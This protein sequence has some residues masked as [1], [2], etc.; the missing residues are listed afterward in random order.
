MAICHILL[1]F[2]SPANGLKLVFEG[3][4]LRQVEKDEHPNECELHFPL[5]GCV[6]ICT[7]VLWRYSEVIFSKPH[8][9]ACNFLLLESN[10]RTHDVTKYFFFFPVGTS[11]P[12]STGGERCFH[13]GCWVGF[14][15]AWDPRAHIHGERATLWTLLWSHF[16]AYL[17]VSHN[18]ASFKV[19]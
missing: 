11:L 3:Y 7:N 1:V 17:R 15:P 12:E 2:P 6:C 19:P 8:K 14:L 10:A 5:C 4:F 9:V 18:P 16:P 13:Y